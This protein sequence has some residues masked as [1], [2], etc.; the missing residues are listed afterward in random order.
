MC[1][2]CGI[3]Y[4]AGPKR[5]G[6]EST[7]RRM[8]DRLAHRGPDGEGCATGAGYCLGH[9]RLAIIDLE[10]GAQP[11][12][13]QDGRFQLVYNGELYNYLELRQQ[14]VQDGVVF[15]TSSD[16][17]VVLQMLIR[18]GAAALEDFNGMFALAFVDRDTG[19][20]LLAR[21]PFGIKP[22]YYASA[23][24]EFLFASEI[25][26]LLAH[27]AV[28]STVNWK[29]L[30]Q[31][32]TFQ[33]CLHGQTLFEGI[34]AVQP[35][36]FL[37]GRGAEVLQEGRY[38]DTNYEVDEHHTDAYFT[39]RLLH[40]LQDSAR[41]QIRSDVPLGAYLSGG[42]DSSVVAS[43]AAEHLGREIP[44]FHGRF[45]EGP[46]Y[47]ESRY[48]RI[49]AESIGADYRETAPSADQFVEAMPRLI[50]HMDEPVAG[51]G[52]FPQYA[53]SRLAA[54]RVKVVLGGQGGDE[55]FGG[56]ARYLIGYLEQALKGAVFRTQEE[57]R[58][59]VTLA[60]IIP[61]LPLLQEYRP[62]LQ[63]FLGEGLF[64]EMG[65]RYFR[66]IDRSPNVE[67]LMTNDARQR[68]DRQGVFADFERVFH[69]PDTKS[70]FNKMTH[71]DQKTL[72][73]ALLQVEDRVSMAV[74]LESRVPLLDR[75]IVDLVTT[76]PPPMKFQGGRTKHVLKQAVADLLPSSVL[77]RSDKMGFPVPLSEW[78]Q[79]G[80]VRDFVCDVLFSRCCRQRGLFRPEALE[81]LVDREARFGR[82]LWGVLCLELWHRQFIDA[83][84]MEF[85]RAA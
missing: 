65:A 80:P 78:M 5:P 7:V 63:Q 64:D 83:T 71:F 34:Q 40:L 46:A 75:R 37:R 50:Y 38:W 18:K 72:L 76:M 52:L 13:S 74:S 43:M 53:V 41:L 22:L 23:E 48:A 4:P 82:Q 69:H 32:L 30:E 56:Y 2:L 29:G 39:D 3:F 9:R 58:H 66:L 59:I 60:S 26:A 85:R 8:M 36:C 6:L 68:F 54:D 35:G 67:S 24:D 42:I 55:I 61:N 28:G 45:A 62:L 33:F 31:Y 16:T 70:Y 25:K 49:V 10:H 1:G 19:Q 73:P 57:G 21:D 14:L 20:W 27:P 11:M 77:D 81:S 84:E 12:A 17:E 51:P 15:R 79:G 47:D 44:V